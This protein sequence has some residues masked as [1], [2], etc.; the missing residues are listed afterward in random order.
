MS[1]DSSIVVA[2]L[3]PYLWVRVDGK[4]SFQNA[5]DLKSF[6]FQMIATGRSRFVIDLC[7]CPMMDSTFMGTL[8][9]IAIRLPEQSPPGKLTVVNANDRNANLLEN[10]GLTKIF[11]VQKDTAG[12]EEQVRQVTNVLEAAPSV[13]LP[14]EQRSKEVLASHETLSDVSDE[15]RERFK[16][17]VEF[18]RS[19]SARMD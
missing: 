1:G 16:D 5:A 14:L 4:G 15:N 3:S 8:V 2:E 19:D 11:P 7:G 18:L 13:D 10:L 6:A 9:G 12:F 17:V